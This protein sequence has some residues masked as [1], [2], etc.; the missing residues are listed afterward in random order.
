MGCPFKKKLLLGFVKKKKKR[1]SNSKGS[2]G[3]LHKTRNIF[4]CSCIS[5][6]LPGFDLLSFIRI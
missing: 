6:A 4:P 1:Q 2:F 3:K 5:R